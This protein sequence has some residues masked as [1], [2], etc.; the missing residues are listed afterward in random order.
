MDELKKLVSSRRG[1]KSHVLKILY[2]VD[3]IMDRL[4]QVKQDDPSSK[5]LSSNTLLLA[6]CSKQLQLKIG[7]FTHLDE[8]IIENLDDKEKLEDTIHVCKSAELQK[9]LSQKIGFIALALQTNSP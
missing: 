3:G 7:I 1:H 2:S 4:S 5:L 8:K 9:T 6:E